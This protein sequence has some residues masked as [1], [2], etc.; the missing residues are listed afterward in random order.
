MALYIKKPSGSY[1]CILSIQGQSAVSYTFGF[2]ALTMVHILSRI[3]MVTLLIVINLLFFGFVSPSS[4]SSFVIVIG[5]S[6]LAV[7]VY[8]F[9]KIAYRS[10]T[11]FTNTTNDQQKKIAL[12]LTIA[13]MFLVLMQSIGQLSARDVWAIVPL[14][15]LLYAYI[16]YPARSSANSST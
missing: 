13:T 10:L 12:F 3:R 6:L 4:A 14:A 11:V 8:A 9:W 5:C 15:V 16:A 7:D 1:E 2:L